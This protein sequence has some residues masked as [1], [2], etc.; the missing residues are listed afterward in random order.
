MDRPETIRAYD[1]VIEQRYPELPWRKP[2]EI[3]TGDYSGL[4]CRLCIARLGFSASRDS[5][6]LYRTL[7]QFFDHLRDT[8]GEQHDN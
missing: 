6:R 7:E 1:A 2:V 3:H 4:A 5:H 8:H